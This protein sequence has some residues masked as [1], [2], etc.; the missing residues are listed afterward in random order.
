M[1]RNEKNKIKKKSKKKI[2]NVM[3]TRGSDGGIGPIAFT[4]HTTDARQRQ[5]DKHK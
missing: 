3:V 5:E 2:N 1:K 4:Q